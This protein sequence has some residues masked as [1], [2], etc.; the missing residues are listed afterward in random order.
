MRLAAK[1]CIRLGSSNYR[2]QTTDYRLKRWADAAR[3]TPATWYS[4]GVAK[5]ELNVCRQV[6][7]GEGGEAGP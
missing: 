4:T 1:M 6:D 3:S 7:D 2:L 5:K